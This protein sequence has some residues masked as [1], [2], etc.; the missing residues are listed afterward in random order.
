M[1]SIS[2]RDDSKA[3]QS[4]SILGCLRRFITS[5]SCRNSARCEARTRINL[6]ANVDPLTS[7]VHMHTLPNLPLYVYAQIQT[8][9][10]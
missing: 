4:S 1:T 7:S 3:S 8:S 9:V 2:S 10:N 6:A 5:I